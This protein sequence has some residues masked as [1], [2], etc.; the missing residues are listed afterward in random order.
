[1]C[2]VD[3]IWGGLGEDVGLGVNVWV[4]D[5]SKLRVEDRLWCLISRD[6]AWYERTSFRI[7]KRISY[8]NRKAQR[9][10]P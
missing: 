4:K 3:G 9:L 5:F 7:P 2:S 10:I 8:P 6:P 1:M